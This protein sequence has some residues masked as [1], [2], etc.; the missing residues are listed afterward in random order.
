MTDQGEQEASQKFEKDIVTPVQAGSGQ[1]DLSGFIARISTPLGASV[2]GT[3]ATTVVHK[4]VE[5]VSARRS[6][7]IAEL[8]PDGANIEQLAKEVVA[9]RLG[10][11]PEEVGPSER[12]RQ[13]Y[14]ALFDRP[15]TD[16]AVAAI[17]DLVLAVNK[18]KKK[19]KKTTSG[20][21]MERQMPPGEA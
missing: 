21:R 5:A 17:D 13:A 7:R 6:N 2:L 20:T 12:R 14:L 4:K 19:K 11:Q 8:H 18:T 16:Q 10:S 15:I 1:L 3:S 9:R